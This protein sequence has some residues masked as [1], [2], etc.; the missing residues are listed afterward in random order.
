V[1]GP[2]I[3]VASRAAASKAAVLLRAACAIYSFYV[4][5]GSS[6]TLS[7]RITFFWSA[8]WW[9]SISIVEA[10]LSAA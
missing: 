10:R 4:S 5:F 6:Q 2:H 7:T 1:D 8:V 9:P 3:E